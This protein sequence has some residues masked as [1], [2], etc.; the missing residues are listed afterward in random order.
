MADDT[1]PRASPPRR[2]P[3]LYRL[4]V[5][6]LV[7]VLVLGLDRALRWLWYLP[8]Y[9]ESRALLAED[10]SEF[11]KDFLRFKPDYL[12][13]WRFHSDT[14]IKVEAYN[15]FKG[16]RLPYLIRT[17][18]LG[19]RGD[20]VERAKAP[21]TLRVVALGGSSTMGPGV[22]VERTY[23]HR[24][25]ALLRS[26]LG[27]RPVEAINAGVDAY[28]AQQGFSMYLRDIRPLSPDLL[29][30]AFDVNEQMLAPATVEE[31]AR[32]RQPAQLE[33]VSPEEPWLVHRERE[34]L[35]SPLDGIRSVLHESGLYYTF[36]FAG[37]WIGG[38]LS[39]SNQRKSEPP[40]RP[41]GTIRCARP[42]VMAAIARP[43]DMPVRAYRYTLMGIGKLAREDGV[44]VIFLSVPVS[45]PEQRDMISPAPY[46]R[47]MA[48][49]ARD[50]PD[51][52][53][54]DAAEAFCR[55]PIGDVMIDEVHPSDMGHGLLARLL[56]EPALPLLRTRD[57][58][59]RG[60]VSGS[61][62]AR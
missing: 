35:R 4:A 19:F 48:E 2:R 56:L 51:R 21:G 15:Y 52:R 40:P 9:S 28:Q 29:V 41:Y 60:V 32:W 31:A 39:D 45:I 20:H 17:N 8:T 43:W 12:L 58:R 34:R 53:H 14:T 18:N 26:R 13:K 23:V 5:V 36:T 59:A 55:H 3:W 27:G 22:P 38:R 7:L 47:I 49:V 62:A 1:T 37:R 11:N 25:A 50:H 42:H 16:V 57:Q 44:P 24:L 61:S 33:V 46:S 54:V 30:V 10:A 6:V